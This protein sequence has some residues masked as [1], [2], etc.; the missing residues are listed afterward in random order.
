MGRTKKLPFYIKLVV[1]DRER[2]CLAKSIKLDNQMGKDDVW[3]MEMETKRLKTADIEVWYKRDINE[4][5][6]QLPMLIENKYKSDIFS[7][8]ITGWVNFKKELVR[9]TAIKLYIIHTHSFNDVK[10]HIGY[11]KKIH[12]LGKMVNHFKSFL[13][14]Y[15]IVQDDA[16]CIYCEEENYNELIRRII[17]KELKKVK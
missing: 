11:L 13:E 16:I 14:R 8:L 15:L 9:A 1:D 7:T 6:Q 2:N 17:K 5:Y 4:E 10:Q 12:K 3:I